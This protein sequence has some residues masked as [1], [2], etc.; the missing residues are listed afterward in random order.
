MI[1]FFTALKTTDL[2]TDERLM[3]YMRNQIR[4]NTYYTR[5]PLRNGQ[6]PVSIY[7]L[8]SQNLIFIYIPF[9]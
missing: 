1:K 6:K 8:N 9:H 5:T 2:I 7:I 3:I 4:L